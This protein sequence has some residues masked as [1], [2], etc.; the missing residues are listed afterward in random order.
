MGFSGGTRIFTKGCQ[1]IKDRPTKKPRRV[2]IQYKYI[3]KKS[4]FLLATHS[5]FP[6]N[7]CSTTGGF[8]MLMIEEK[9]LGIGFFHESLH[10]EFYASLNLSTW[11]S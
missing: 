7:M 3:K 11:K 2:N 4:L 10:N 6:R 1:N 5:N 9:L 8:H